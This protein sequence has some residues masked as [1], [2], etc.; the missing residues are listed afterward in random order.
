MG[1]LCSKFREDHVTFLSRDAG[2][3][4]GRTDVYVILHSIQ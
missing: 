1:N 4:D 2:Q 3:T